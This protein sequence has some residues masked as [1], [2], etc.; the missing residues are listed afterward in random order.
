MNSNSVK[1]QSTIIPPTPQ[2]STTL[3]PILVPF[4]QDGRF[5][6]IDAYG[7][8][9]LIRRDGPEEPENY[10]DGLEGS[11][12]GAAFPSDDAV[13]ILRHLQGV[14]NPHVEIAEVAQRNGSAHITVRNLPKLDRDFDPNSS[15]L[16]VVL[17]DQNISLMTSHADGHVCRRIIGGVDIVSKSSSSF[18]LAEARAL[19]TNSIPRMART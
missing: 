8:L 3:S 14:K 6:A 12:A 13:L 4:N 15:G 9:W 17:D 5:M 1:H 7:R 10:P 11:V 2:R 19:S 18:K 16:A